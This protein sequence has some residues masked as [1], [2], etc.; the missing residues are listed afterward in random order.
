MEKI[1][2][3]VVKMDNDQYLAIEQEDSD[4]VFA[5]TTTDVM[6][7]EPYGL[8][9]VKAVVDALKHGK[10]LDGTCD[11]K[12]TKEVFNVYFSSENKHLKP[13]SYVKV[14]T[15]TTEEHFI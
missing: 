14:V 8:D 1:E 7:A 2:A 4:S 13:K 11:G 3:Y 9:E 5:S 6:R 10:K 15:D 12:V